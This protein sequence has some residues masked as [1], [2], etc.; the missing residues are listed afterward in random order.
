MHLKAG[1][2]VSLSHTKPLSVKLKQVHFLGCF[3]CSDSAQIPDVQIKS[4]EPHSGTGTYRSKT[5]NNHAW[6]MATA[7]SMGRAGTACAALLSGDW[8]CCLWALSNFLL[9]FRHSIAESRRCTPTLPPGRGSCHH[10][11]LGGWVWG[12]GGSFRQPVSVRLIARAF[13]CAQWGEG[14]RGRI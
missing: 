5:I 11:Q 13:P 4:P 7:C 3:G 14:E 9:T 6:E 12:G 1:G 8:A 10:Y 2:F